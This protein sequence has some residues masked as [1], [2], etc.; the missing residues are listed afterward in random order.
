MRGFLAC[1]VAWL[2]LFALALGV[3]GGAYLHV[4]YSPRFSITGKDSVFDVSHDGEWLMTATFE[5]GQ[6]IGP[7]R[8]WSVRTGEVTATYLSEPP[9]HARQVEV[10]GQ[11][12]VAAGADGVLHIVDRR[13]GETKDV[14]LRAE[15]GRFWCHGP[16][17]EIR[18]DRGDG[19]C[20][21][22][23]LSKGRVVR[24]LPARSRLHWHDDGRLFIC[25]AE[26]VQIWNLDPMRM[27]KELAIACDDLWLSSGRWLATWKSGGLEIGDWTIWDLNTG[28]K[29][30]YFPRTNHPIFSNDGGRIA[31]LRNYSEKEAC[32]LH[33]I[34][35]DSGRTVLKRAV[36]YGSGFASFSLD[37][38]LLAIEGDPELPNSM[39][40]DLSSGKVSWN[41]ERASCWF[42]ARSN[43]IL[44]RSRPGPIRDARTGDI[45]LEANAEWIAFTFDERFL[46]LGS[47]A[48]PKDSRWRWLSKLLPALFGDG[49]LVRVLEVKDDLREVFRLRSRSQPGWQISKDGSLLVTYQITDRSGDSLTYR[50]DVWNMSPNRARALAAI[51][52]G[53]VVAAGLALKAWRRRR[54]ANRVLL[55]TTP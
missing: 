12:L 8:L 42:L 11:W 33:V 53:A 19:E 31:L 48:A 25:T 16:W 5:R 10:R 47:K 1:L 43:L 30:H 55:Q 17:C 44:P 21:L 3:G 18:I 52:G 38:Q 28:D 9:H 39:M 54:K 13:T 2:P 23:D 36:P 46:V 34:E 4:R 51:S 50:I 49:E 20:L 22:V 27:D 6:P 26:S 15:I 32:E 14:A 7:I 24:R 29:H 40:I 45:I 37:G 41:E 35:T